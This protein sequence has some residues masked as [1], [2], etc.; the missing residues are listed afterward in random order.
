MYTDPTH[1]R[2][3]NPGKVEGNPVFVDLDAFDP[4]KQK[5]DVMKDHYR[6]GGLGD[7]IVKKRPS[8]FY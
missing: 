8:D 1:L 4:D 7:V 6:Q 5:L 3:E 2:V